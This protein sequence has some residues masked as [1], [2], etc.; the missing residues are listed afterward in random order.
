[1]VIL[2]TILK[3]SF[4]FLYFFLKLLPVKNKILFMSRQND[5]PSI[6][7]I[8]L[9][10]EL[11]KR[12]SNYEIMILCKRM[13]NDGLSLINYYFYSVRQ[14]YHL[15]TSKVCIVD[16]YIITIS[17]LKHK[18]DLKIMQLWH[19]PAAVKKFGFQTLHK[20]RNKKG[21]LYERTENIARLMDNAQKL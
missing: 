20:E 7:Y 6:D 17:I 16:G 1:M 18:K 9:I 13:K 10:E 11:K 12:S 19:S 4:R 15:A 21:I 3:I 14:M 8:C 2:V 5:N